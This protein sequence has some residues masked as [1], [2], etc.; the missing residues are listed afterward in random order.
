MQDL[1]D[2]GMRHLNRFR[3]TELAP[4]PPTP[5]S[6]VWEGL[7]NVKNGNCSKGSFETSSGGLGAGVP[8]GPNGSRWEL[9]FAAIY[10][11]CSTGA[12]QDLPDVGMRHLSRS[13]V[14]ELAPN[15]LLRVSRVP[16]PLGTVP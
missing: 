9:H 5:G 4:N 12:V 6:G 16:K 3:V 2:V 15:A 14:T 13:R 8:I 1:P 7:G 10:Y 11:V